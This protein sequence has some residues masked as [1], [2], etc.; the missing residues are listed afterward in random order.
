M[1]TIADN[2]HFNET[3]TVYF[4]TPETTVV[5]NATGLPAGE[6]YHSNFSI[7]DHNDDVVDRGNESVPFSECN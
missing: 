4:V 1:L 7:N 6:H 5:I 2:D 3:S